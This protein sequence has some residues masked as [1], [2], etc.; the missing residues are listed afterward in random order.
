M[1]EWKLFNG[2]GIPACS[3][4]AFFREHPWVPPEAQAG[5]RERTAMAARLIRSVVT[6]YAP[7]SISDLGCGDGSLMHMIRDLPVE[8]WGYDAGAQNVA[9]ARAKGL[10]VTECD[11]LDGDVTF[12]ELVVCCEVVEHLARPHD[13]LRELPAKLLV[14]S[15][16]SAETDEWHYADHTW[17]WDFEGYAELAGGAGWHVEGHVECDGGVNRHGGVTRRQRFQAMFAVRP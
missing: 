16:P 11:F 8:L 4:V 9:K 10:N 6:E 13:F 17:A 14:L 3:T 5:H 15:S 1:S 7:A 12:G 2:D